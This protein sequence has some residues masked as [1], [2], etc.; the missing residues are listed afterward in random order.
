MMAGRPGG[1]SPE[2]LAV[3][4]VAHGQEAADQ[5]CTAGLTVH[6]QSREAVAPFD[7]LDRPTS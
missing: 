6:I 5:T 2:P 3:E 1:P 7:G 4:I